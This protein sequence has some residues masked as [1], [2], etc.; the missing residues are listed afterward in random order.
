MAEDR[1]TDGER[2]AELLASELTGVS[3]GSMDRLSVVDADPD[4]TPAAEGTFA[5]RVAVDGDAVATVSIYPDH[6]RVAVDRSSVADRSI[7]VDRSE[8]EAAIGP[9]ISVERSE[10]TVTLR[11]EY[12]AAVKR[13]SDL[14]VELVVD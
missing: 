8:E 9:G 2:I 5:Y 11:I 6:A 12:A 10:T 13:A 3:A 14:L 4:A 7:V 1:V